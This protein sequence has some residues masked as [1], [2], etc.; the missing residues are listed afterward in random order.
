[1]LIAYL[2]RHQERVDYWFARKGGYPIG[3]PATNA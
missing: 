1:M 3:S 2:Q